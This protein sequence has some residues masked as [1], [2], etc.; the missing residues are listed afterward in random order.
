MIGPLGKASGAPTATGFLELP[1]PL[2]SWLAP[3]HKICPWLHDAKHDNLYHQNYH[4]LHAFLPLVRR[5][6]R[7][8]T[9]YIY[10]GEV[11]VIL[12]KVVP[13]TISKVDNNV[14][15]VKGDGP[16]LPRFQ[17]IKP[18]FWESLHLKGMEGEC[19]IMCQIEPQTHFG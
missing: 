3:G 10:L 7:S 12:I 11:N 13:I 19:G 9:L 2:G 8:G 17:P 4:K 14:A 16:P 5:S 15:V 6:T 1:H 18:T